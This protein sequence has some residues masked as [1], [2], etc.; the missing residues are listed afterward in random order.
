MR[1][2]EPFTAADNGLIKLARDTIGISKERVGSPFGAVSGHIHQ[3]QPDGL[4]E[5]YVSSFRGIDFK[6]KLQNGW[7]VTFFMNND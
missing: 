7:S 1:C 3:R 2:D 5:C 4:C 6:R